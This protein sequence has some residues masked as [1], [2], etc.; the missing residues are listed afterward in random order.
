MC[1]WLA[2]GSQH[3]ENAATQLLMRRE[4]SFTT[5]DDIYIRYLSY[6]D[7]AAFKKD[8]VAKLPH[9]IDIGAVF[10]APAKDHLAVAAGAFQPCEREVCLC[11]TLIAPRLSLIHI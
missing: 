4:F 5:G 1:R 10:T 8:L 3:D 9:K 7:A 2:Y 11:P 6:E